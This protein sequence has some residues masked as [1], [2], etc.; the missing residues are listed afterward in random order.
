M[1][2]MS[3]WDMAKRDL[4]RL[5]RS[6][7]KVLLVVCREIFDDWAIGK[8]LTSRLAGY[9]VHRMGPYRIIYA[10]RESARVEIVAIGHRR[11]VYERVTKRT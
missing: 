6:L 11:D 3:F 5:P 4:E 8:P 1:V 9:R 10:V 2:K 7:R